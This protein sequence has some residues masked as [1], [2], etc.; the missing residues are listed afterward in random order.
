MAGWMDGWIDRKKER[1]VERRKELRRWS[2]D[3][4]VPMGIRNYQ[5]K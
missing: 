1:K 4:S 5:N 2:K 3:E